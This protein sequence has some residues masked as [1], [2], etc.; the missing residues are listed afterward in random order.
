[1]ISLFE[2]FPMQIFAE[3]P[4]SEYCIGYTYKNGKDLYN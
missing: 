1:M 3:C 4:Y 2:T